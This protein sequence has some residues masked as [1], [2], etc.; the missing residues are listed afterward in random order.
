M[1]LKN[2]SNWRYRLGVAAVALLMLPSVTLVANTQGESFFPQAMAAPVPADKE[3]EERKQAEEEIADASLK[4]EQAHAQMEGMNQKL[5]ALYVE[6]KK[7]ET[8]IPGATAELDQAET[9]LANHQRR[10]AEITQRLDAAKNQLAK[11]DE[12]IAQSTQELNETQE[13]LGDLARRTYRGEFSSSPLGLVFAGEK[14]ADI[15]DLTAAANMATMVQMQAITEVENGLATNR[16][17]SERQKALTNSIGTLQKEAQEMVTKSAALRD[18][19]DRKLSSLKQLQEQN[20]ILEA[21]INQ[22]KDEFAREEAAQEARRLEA[23]ARIAS[24]DEAARLRQERDRA[25]ALAQNRAYEGDIGP[26][27]GDAIWGRPI[28][29]RITVLSPWGY[30]VH[31]ITGRRKLH[32]GV[33]LRSP[34]GEQQYAVHDGTVVE[35]YYDSG[36][37]NMV[38]LDLG[39]FGGHRWLSRQCHLSARFV[40]LGQRVRRGQV[41]GLTGSTGAVTGPHVH[42]EIWRDGI[43]VNPMPYI[44]G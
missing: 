43:C 8:Q 23:E 24:F 28:Q 18:E 27:T 40:Q 4:I 1:A 13:A 34:V 29:G 37:G 41:I 33:D 44:G 11:L 32:E 39:I 38:T 22:K 25:L 2:G 12:Q 5:G 16:N 30:R 42:F 31:P 10:E 14:T 21:E 9:E 19:K 36:C 35:S 3:S 15:A 20:R 17:R 7:V 26:S 6:M